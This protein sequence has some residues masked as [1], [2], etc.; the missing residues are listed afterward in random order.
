LSCQRFCFE[1]LPISE[2]VSQAENLVIAKRMEVEEI[3]DINVFHAELIWFSS[4]MNA[5]GLIIVNL[6]SLHF[7]SNISVFD[8]TVKFSVAINEIHGCDMVRNK[9]EYFFFGFFVYNRCSVGIVMLAREF[10]SC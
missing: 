9:R 10:M 2:H 6:N 8:S 4:V 5:A 3:R 1:G 7:K